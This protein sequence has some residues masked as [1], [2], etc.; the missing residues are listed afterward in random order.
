MRYLPLGL[1]ALSCTFLG[2][3]ESTL[4][5]DFHLEGEHFRSACKIQNAKSLLSCGVELLTAQPLHQAAGNLAPQNGF[6][7]G[8]A[9]VGGKNTTNWRD[10]WNIDAV[11]SY[12]ASYRAGGY[13]TM[14]HTPPVKIRVIQPISSGTSASPAQKSKPAPN[15]VHRYTVINLYAQ[16]ISLNQ[17]FYF[18]LGNASLPQGQTAY[19]MSETVIGLSA[20][21]PAFEI[22]AIRK[23]NL[24]LNGEINGR[25]VGLRGNTSTSVPSIGAVYNPATAPGLDSQPAMAQLG[26]G[27]RLEPEIGD[28]VELNYLG[29]F[30]QYAPSAG[31]HQSFLRWTLD[32]NHTYALYGQTHSS[33]S[34]ASGHGPDQCSD[35]KSPCPS[36]SYSRNLSGSIGVRLL[37][38]ESVHSSS[39]SVPFYFQPTLGGSNIDGQSM[40]PSYPDY[41]FRAPNLIY[42]GTNLEHS[43]WGPLGFA[44]SWDEGKVEQAR[45]KIN[46]DHLKHSFATGVTIRAGG[47]PMVRLLFAWGG[48][49]GTHTIF[50]MNTSLL[51]GSARPSLY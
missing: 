46:F 35:L 9:F 8:I 40:L 39:N 34:S 2:A 6:A 28:R 38:S 23:L 11:G 13:L 15:F 30:E 4:H 3:Q 36:I 48:R 32:L 50:N 19:G 5:A 44:A 51:G 21:K 29:K 49:E 16:T 22:A 24:S 45:D 43:V 42:L 31:S 41:R 18:G 26:E 27:I 20:I 12:N 1:L 10:S 37:L 47:F 7:A 33:A 25:M 17:L 14:V